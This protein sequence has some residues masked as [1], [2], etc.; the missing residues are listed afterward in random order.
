MS[1]RRP[2]RFKG[3]RAA[4][5]RSRAGAPPGQ[6]R[7]CKVSNDLSR[8]R[9]RGRGVRRTQTSP[10]RVTRT[11]YSLVAAYLSLLARSRMIPLHVH[12]APQKVAGIACLSRSF[13]SLSP[14]SAFSDQ[15]VQQS[16]YARPGQPSVD[17]LQTDS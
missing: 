6:C 11:Y 16:L 14:S 1:R 9:R 15:H 3:A 13:E 5:T 7:G 17:S 10:A 8:S 12:S 4:V 2:L